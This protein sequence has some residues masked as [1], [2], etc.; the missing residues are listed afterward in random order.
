VKEAHAI[1]ANESE[2]ENAHAMQSRVSK[3]GIYSY[4]S[5]EGLS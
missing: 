1:L 5:A 4:I 3:T 2:K